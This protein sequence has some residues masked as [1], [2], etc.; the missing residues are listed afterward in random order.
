[1]GCYR[2]MARPGHKWRM[3]AI[4]KPARRRSRHF[5]KEWR[6]HRHLTQ[7]QLA[8]RIEMSAPNYGRIENGKVPYNQDFLEAL[9]EALNCE[10]ADLIMRNPLDTQAPWSIVE[11]L[12]KASPEDRKRVE[13]VVETLLKT[14]T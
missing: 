5:I 6:L 7:E 10:P 4:S 3:V 8:A 13:A 9:A 12:Q 14:G 1:M 11:A 2:L